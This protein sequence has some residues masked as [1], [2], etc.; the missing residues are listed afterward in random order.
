MNANEILIVDLES[1]SHSCSP[2]RPAMR[3]GR[4][5]QHAPHA[6]PQRGCMNAA[7]LRHAPLAAHTWQLGSRSTQPE[8]VLPPRKRLNAAG[9]ASSLA[10]GSLCT[11]SNCERSFCAMTSSTV[12]A[13]CPSLRVALAKS[14][15]PSSTAWAMRVKHV[16]CLATIW[17]VSFESRLQSD[18]GAKPGAAAV[19]EQCFLQGRAKFRAVR[20][21][22]AVRC[23]VK[24]LAHIFV[25]Q[26]CTP[27]ELG[28]M[29]RDER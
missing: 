29:Q 28:I 13:G 21:S 24:Y 18:G 22:E 23:G 2:S 17:G 16:S 27:I 3:G 6:A 20:S 11:A 15:V 10:V 7:F 14:K 26:R 4:A 19:V 25:S 5:C 1:T 9:R 12:S 8:L